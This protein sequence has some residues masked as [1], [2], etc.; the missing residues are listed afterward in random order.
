MHLF[1]GFTLLEGLGARKPSK[2]TLKAVKTHKVKEDKS[3]E[4]ETKV[5]V[6]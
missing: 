4:E 1:E 3:K 6:K 5:K 2:G